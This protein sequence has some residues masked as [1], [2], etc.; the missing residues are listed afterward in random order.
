MRV[1]DLKRLLR[2]HGLSTSGRKAE[3]EARLN[4]FNEN[5]NNSDNRSK[6]RKRNDD[7]D[8]I[9]NDNNDSNNNKNNSNGYNYHGKKS[10]SGGTQALE[11]TF[12]SFK[13]PETNEIGIDGM[14]KLCTSI[15]VNPEDP[16]MIVIAWHMKAQNLGVFSKEEFLQGMREM[17]C[18][19]AEALKSRLDTLRSL[20]PSN[21]D[22]KA[23]YKFAYGWACEPG[24]KS[25]SKETANQ[26]WQLLLKDVNFPY[27]K[28][29]LE[30]TAS[31]NLRGITKD[32]WNQ[33]LMFIN[34]LDQLNFDLKE[35]DVDAGAWPVLIDEWV[36]FELEKEKK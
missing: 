27:L 34:H 29:F 3:L 22:F 32:T 33:V 20:A 31:Y 1:V 10:K 12:T 5:K 21:P 8:N 14:L 13:D 7:T 35:F 28:S 2:Q 25:L 15:D 16:V 24:Q 4:A 26:L 18:D 23:I 36:S 17:R 30:F 11:E 19:T 9:N 6:K